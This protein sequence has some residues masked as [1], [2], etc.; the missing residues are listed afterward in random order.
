MLKNAMKLINNFLDKQDSE[1]ITRYTL[2]DI[3][4]NFLPSVSGQDDTYSCKD[5]TFINNQTGFSHILY[6]NG[7]STTDFDRYYM[8]LEQIEKQFDIK[9]NELWRVRLGLTLN[10][11][12]KGVHNPHSDF[13]EPHYTALYYIGQSDGDTIFYNELYDGCLNKELTINKTNPHT[14][15]QMVLFD[16]LTLHSSNPPKNNLYRMTLNINFI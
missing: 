1:F 2:E 8:F 11:N 9:I 12:T 15:N 6:G 3:K 5:T 13:K 14:E 10:K 7:Y 4:W 16:G